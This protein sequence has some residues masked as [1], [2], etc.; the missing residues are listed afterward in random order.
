[1]AMGHWSPSLSPAFRPAKTIRGIEA[2]WPRV[3]DSGRPAT[4]FP[5]HENYPRDA[6]AMGLEVLGSARSIIRH[7]A[8]HTQGPA[9]LPTDFHPVIQFPSRNYP[10]SEDSAG[11]VSSDRRRRRSSVAAAGPPL[12]GGVAAAA[13]SC[14]TSRPAIR[15]SSEGTAAQ[16]H[17]GVTSRM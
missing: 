1:M 16:A 4:G 15:Y 17:C 5:S 14:V 6:A 12:H 13:A 8:K 2:A 7:P 10:L 9:R 3:T 11:L